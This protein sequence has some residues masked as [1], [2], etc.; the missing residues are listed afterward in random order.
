MFEITRRNL[1]KWTTFTAGQLL[2]VFNNLGYADD[3]SAEALENSAREKATAFLDQISPYELNKLQSIYFT[4]DV[5]LKVA[6]NI[7]MKVGAVIWV[8]KEGNGF[9][10]SF[11]LAEPEGVNGWSWLMLMLFGKHTQEYKELIQGIETKLVERFHHD[12]GRFRTDLLEEIL[13]EEKYYENQ[14]AIKVYFDYEQQKI[15]FWEDKFDD[16]F[17]KILPYTG[18]MAPMTAFFNYLF[19]GHAETEM[20]IVNVL[21]QVEDDD[22][23]PETPGIK[24]VRYLFESQ[25]T[26]FGVNTSGKYPGYPMMVKFKGGNFL[27][28]VFGEYLYYQLS[29]DARSR[30]RLPFAAHVLGI[31]SKNKKRKKIKRLKKKYPHRKSFE[32]ELLDEVD[33]ILAARNIKV[34]LSGVEVSLKS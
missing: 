29:H 32:K 25:I 19:S 11:K 2:L 9:T 3:P 21:K 17:S 22:S 20:S 23:S 31:I 12:G 8:R 1:F 26:S 16:S 5:H 13:P 28:I 24:I 27:D 33:D 4:Y 34:Y 15:V 10:A 6:M 7:R 14:T 30:I 18:Q